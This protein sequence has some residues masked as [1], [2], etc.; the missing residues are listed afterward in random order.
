MQ[1][2]NNFTLRNIG[3]IYFILPTKGTT[4]VSADQMLTTNETGAFL[5]NCLHTNTTLDELTEKLQNCYNI[6]AE[7]AQEDIKIFLSAL[8]KIHAIISSSDH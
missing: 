8:K 1:A 6:D 2:N 3:D 7:T 4:F 5:W